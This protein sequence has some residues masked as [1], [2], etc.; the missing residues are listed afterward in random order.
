[1][2]RP[3]PRSPASH[4]PWRTEA[5][6]LRPPRTPGRLDQP[7]RSGVRY[8][9]S[10][11]VGRD[12]DLERLRALM[13]GSRVVSIVGPGG[14]GKTRLAHVLAQLLEERALAARP[15]AQ[16]DDDVVASIVAQLDG[17]PLAI[18]LAAAKVRAMSVEEIDR[19]LENR[20][21]LLR[22]GD[23]SAPD[24]HQTLLSVRETRA[25][26]RYRMLET[27]R[28]F[29]RMQLVDVGE[30][31]EARDA[32]RRWATAY[33]RLHGARLPSAEQLAAILTGTPRSPRASA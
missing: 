23:R 1:M 2:Q 7:V 27:V 4:S 14:L 33:A 28:E 21:V 3:R 12:R 26:L 17:L 5:R 6:P 20:F 13:A 10:T 11:L 30:D 19:R 31:R 15:T 8:D 24:R 18:E 25:G 29:G 16:L 9:A 22:G 32:L